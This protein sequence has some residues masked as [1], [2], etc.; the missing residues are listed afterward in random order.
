MACLDVHLSS[1]TGI[2]SNFKNCI[3]DPHCLCVV[4]G[5]SSYS[6]QGSGGDY[7]IASQ[8][9]KPVL[10][11]Y[12]WGKPQP[13][14][15]CHIQEITTA[16]ACDSTGTYLLGGTK[17]GWI[18]C[19]E[20]G[21]GLL[22]TS[23]QAHFKAVTKIQFTACSQLAVSCSEDG[24][25]RAWEVASIVQLDTSA[26]K[27]KTTTYTPFRS[28]SPHTLA[29]KDMVLCGSAATSLRALTCSIDRT[30]VIFDLHSNKQCLRLALE[31]P[32]ECLTCSRTE[33][34]VFLGA[35]NGQIFVL[36]LSLAAA[37]MTAAHAQMLVVSGH[38]AQT[39]PLAGLAASAGNSLSSSSSSSSSSSHRDK[40]YSVLEGHT[41]SVTGLACSLDNCTLVSGSE[42]GS[43]RVWDIWTRQCLRESKP[44]HKAA[45]SSILLLRRP[46]LLSAGAHKPL[47]TPMEHL[48]KYAD[49]TATT[50]T[51]MVLGPRIMG[52]HRYS[53]Q[54]GALDLSVVPRA[55][56]RAPAMAVAAEGAE[57][58]G[59][60]PFAS[61][62]SSS[63][64]S[65]G[66]SSGGGGTHAQH[67]LSSSDDFIAFSTGPEA[68][69]DD[70]V[71][72]TH[73]SHAHAH[74]DDNDNDNNTSADNAEADDLQRRLA[75]AQSDCE[76][77]KAVAMGL[78]RRLEEGASEGPASSSSSAAQASSDS[79]GGGSKS[80]KGKK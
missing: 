56:R 37:G 47:L 39:R 10:N 2:C 62:S 53:R 63:S 74:T 40:P 3:T 31:Q 78:K 21:T 26:A 9:K 29:V 46:E 8:S 38:A 34:F 57:A 52:G 5:P 4:S 43:L 42:D 54:T 44:L 19:W 24:M 55:G 64:G 16:L 14:Q 75:A 61:S 69:W 70:E 65:G 13:H 60:V 22:L 71:A 72:P 28:W 45:I 7:I 73:S 23:W 30:L 77:W 80:K 67:A 25:A 35:T 50:T 68:A 32:I 51:K 11:V 36:D 17:K 66:G 79:A 48:K 6:G 18:Y 20:V 76:R 58:E 15:Q 12:Q 41:R 33:D 49:T 59:F 27:K 1:T